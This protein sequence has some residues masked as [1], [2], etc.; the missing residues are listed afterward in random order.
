MGVC[1]FYGRLWVFMGIY[2]GYIGVNIDSYKSPIDFHKHAHTPIAFINTLIPIF[3][4]RINMLWEFVRV[5][6][7]LWKFKEVYG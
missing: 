6:G 2:R 3:I 5:Y 1:A 4:H 7:S